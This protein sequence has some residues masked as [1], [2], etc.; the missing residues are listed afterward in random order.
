MRNPAELGLQPYS[1]REP[2]LRPPTDEEVAA[3]ESSFDMRLPQEY[4]EFLRKFNGAR[5]PKLS[6]FT[7][8]S[9]Y[10]TVID[11]FYYLLPENPE[12]VDRKHHPNGWE[13]GNLWAETRELRAAIKRSDGFKGLADVREDIT[14]RVV[15]FGIDSGGA[16]QF[17]FD[18][19]VS[20][21]RVCLA[22]ASRGFALVPLADSFAAFIDSLHEF[23][24]E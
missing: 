22:V 20:S 10:T 4:V 19:R 6:A 13:F 18:L 9:G 12:R 5:Y 23:E 16:S 11:R 1:R 7:T 8:A 21:R 14:E 24:D 17:V 3:F 2:A 15:P